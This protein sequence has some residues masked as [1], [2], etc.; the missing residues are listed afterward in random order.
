[1]SD[2][3]EIVGEFLVESYENLDRFDEDLLAL[4][5][6]PTDAATLG[7]IFRTVHTIKGT[8]GF[9]GFENLESLTHSAENLLG[10]LR[11][12]LLTMD[13]AAASLLLEAGDKV[14]GV[15][16]QIE[17]CGE[18]PAD[19]HGGLVARL[20]AMVAGEDAAVPVVAGGANGDGPDTVADEVAEDAEPVAEADEPVADDDRYDRPLGELLVG[21]GSATP[22]DVSLA[23]ASQDL[24]DNR[25][26]GQILSEQSRVPGEEV[27]AAL[28]QQAGSGRSMADN[29][30][31]IDVGLLDALMDL[32]GELV[33]AR[34]QIVQLTGG[35]DDPTLAAAGQQLNLITTELQ[36]AATKTRMQPI[37]SSFSK[38]PRIV[39]DLAVAGGKQVKLT[40]EGEET[41]LDRSVLEAIRDPL[42]HAVRNAIDHG[43]EIPDVRESAGKPVEGNVLLRA[44]HEGGQVTIEISDDGAG[45]DPMRMR[46]KAIEKGVISREQASALSDREAM[47]LIFAAGFS[48]AEKVTNVSGRGVGM[49][50]VRTNVERIG[51]SVELDSTIGRGTTV[52]IKIPLTLAIIP[53]LVL[54]ANGQR[55]AIPQASLQEL[56]RVDGG[57]RG[58]VEMIHGAEVYRL[59]GRLLPLVH[60]RAALGLPPREDRGEPKSVV[61]LESDSV[62]FG[63]VVDEV[64]DTAEIVVKPLG[65]Q[66]RSIDVFS[67]ATILGD[68]NVALILD[69]LG[70]ARGANVSAVEDQ[71]VEEET[72]S[73]DL[74]TAELLIVATDDDERL[75]V[76]LESIDRL[77]ELDP[78]KLERTSG[79]TVIQY[80]DE[81]M[82]LVPFG[83]HTISGSAETL[84]TLVTRTEAGWLGLV[85]SRIVDVV[86]VGR[87]Q[88]TSEDGVAII[89]GHVTRLADVAG[90]AQA[91]TAGGAW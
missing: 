18:E 85:V 32:V 74:G 24:G 17:S 61:V 29:S 47:D 31:R 88:L 76:A 77:E 48:T 60:L 12:G 1:M 64:H 30:I 75:A 2:L 28:K 89:D 37:G 14:R 27:D 73:V 57:E 84:P 16:A 63:L 65:A 4:E 72:T 26:I 79:S 59:R 8:C 71:V 42:T 36:E 51:G 91:H 21:R 67:G 6:D 41:E 11:D 23:L 81:V 62:R 33:L 44:Y 53:A 86:S 25:M 38:L 19:D 69:V 7:S 45:I 90:A 46:A 35:V 3:D 66:L 43:I 78:Q 54:G 56:V 10:L 80:R 83:V 20:D 82:S 52:K 22:D 87:S 68:G 13:E 15:L 39:R 5:R 55:Y 70:L 49:D 40:M 34:N 9:L 50:V 58:K